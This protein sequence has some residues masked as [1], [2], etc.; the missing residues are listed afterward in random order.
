M[1]GLKH[2]KNRYF[3][4]I[5]TQKK[6]TCSKSQRCYN[7]VLKGQTPSGQ[8]RTLF[9]GYRVWAQVTLAPVFH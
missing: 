8:D 1:C 9:K 7:P 6:Q 2:R 4:S 5:E 3:V